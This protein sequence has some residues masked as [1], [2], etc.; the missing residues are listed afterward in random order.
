MT[1]R[2][3]SIPE[4][5]ADVRRQL[6]PIRE[7]LLFITG[8]APGKLDRPASDATLAEVISKIKEIMDRIELQ[9]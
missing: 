6:G 9:R 5:Q 8:T 2:A 1:Q 7:Q 4:Q 3:A